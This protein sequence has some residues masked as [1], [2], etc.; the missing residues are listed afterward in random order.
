MEC[1]TRT[2]AEGV[3]TTVVIAMCTSV[4]WKVKNF[5]RIEPN[6]IY[7]QRTVIKAQLPPRQGCGKSYFRFGSHVWQQIG[8]VSWYNSVETTPYSWNVCLPFEGSHELSQLIN[9]WSAQKCAATDLRIFSAMWVGLCPVKVWY[10]HTTKYYAAL[11]RNAVLT[12]ATTWM[13]LDDTMLRK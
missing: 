5:L 6:P 13:S 7:I 2:P 9:T 8:L 12:L 1:H 3:R 4:N 10:I 11:K